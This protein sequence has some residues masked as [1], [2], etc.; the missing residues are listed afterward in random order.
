[1]TPENSSNKTRINS[2]IVLIFQFLDRFNEVPLP[3]GNNYRLDGSSFLVRAGS[4]WIKSDLTLNDFLTNVSSLESADLRD[5]FF[6]CI[7][8]DE[9]DE[10]RKKILYHSHPGKTRI[11]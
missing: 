9:A 4:D 7:G 3:Y 6:R 1:M 10:W 11:Q 5:I 2:P 8:D